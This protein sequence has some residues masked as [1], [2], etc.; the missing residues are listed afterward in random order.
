MTTL[1]EALPCPFCG[2]QHTLQV[3]SGQELMGEDQEFWQHSESFGVVCDASTPDGKG[4]CGAT[5]GFKPTEEGAITAWNIRAALAQQGEQQSWKLVPVEPTDAMEIA[6]ALAYEQSKCHDNIGPL[7]DAWSAMLAA[8]P[9]P[10]A[11]EITGCACRWDADD[12]RIATCVRH[13]GWLDV[14]SEWADRAKAAESALQSAQPV[15]NQSLTTQQAQPTCKQDLQ[16]ETAQDGL[17][18]MCP[19]IECGR[20]KACTRVVGISCISRADTAPQS[21]V[22]DSLTHQGCISNCDTCTYHH[23]SP[24]HAGHCYMFYEEPQGVCGQWKDYAQPID[25]SPQRVEKTG[26]GGHIPDAGKMVRPINCGTGHCSC[27][28]CVMPV[29]E[30]LSDDEITAIAHRKATRY[31]H[32]VAP[33]QV[34]YGFSVMHLLDFARAVEAAHGIS[35]TTK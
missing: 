20:K 26:N 27:I 4:G 23:Q 5:G 3:I 14:V 7:Q 21:T 10:Q 2:K 35:P 32:A 6:G 15:V 18:K 34:T 28:E 16:V 33:G 30:A 24:A 13:Q 9:A 31:T 25:T 12:K 11:Q 29:A 17:V 22:K 19:D 8:A 1:Q